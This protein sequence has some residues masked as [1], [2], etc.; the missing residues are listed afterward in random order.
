MLAIFE[1]YEW[2]GKTFPLNPE[3]I[4]AK[5]WYRLAN[6]GFLYIAKRDK[7]GRPVI[8]MN[9][10]RIVQFECEQDDLLKF[11]DYFFTFCIE[12]LMVPGLIETWIMVVD[13]N[14]V[15]STS[16]PFTKIKAII[17]NGSKNYRGRMYRQYTIN[18]SWF[19]RKAFSGMTTFLDEFTQQKLNMLDDCKDL[20][21]HVTPE[22]LEQKYGGKLPNIVGNYFPPNMEIAG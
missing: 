2:L 5:K 14:N 13:L 21:Q 8:V 17:A 18:A 7:K 1:H 16:V 12:K 6:A 19:V 3:G 9:V 10:E 4:S 22:C 11:C 20:L 15:S